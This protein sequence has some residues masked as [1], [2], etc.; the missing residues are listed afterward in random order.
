MNY[1]KENPFNNVILS[2]FKKGKKQINFLTIKEVNTLLDF[3]KNNLKHIHTRYKRYKRKRFIQFCK[4]HG[5]TSIEKTDSFN[6]CP[7]YI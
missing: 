1:T 7:F 3:Y 5:K 6:N 4:I 2:E